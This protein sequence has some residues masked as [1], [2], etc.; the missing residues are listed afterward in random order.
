MGETGNKQDKQIKHNV[1]GGIKFYGGKKQ[2]RAC[3]STEAMVL[4]RR[5][6]TEGVAL[7]QDLKMAREEAVWQS[8]EECFKQRERHV[9][10][11]WGRSR[12][13]A[14]G[15]AWRKAGWPEERKAVVG[16][17]V[18]R[19][20]LCGALWATARSAAFIPSWGGEGKDHGRILSPRWRRKPP[21]CVK[22]TVGVQA[23]MATLK[24]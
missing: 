14:G 9:Q 11:P 4:S 5:G 3:G 7:G 2:G 8:G 10:R 16:R 12:S 18:L 13:C 24:A 21:D 19:T 23:A 15:A 20:R 6:L 17:V 22:S 1:A